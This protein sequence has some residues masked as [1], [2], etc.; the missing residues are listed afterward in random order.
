MNTI[1]KFNPLFKIIPARDN[2]QN[3][4]TLAQKKEYDAPLEERGTKK[5][6]RSVEK[7]VK[8]LSREST[9]RT[10]TPELSKKP[11]ESWVTGSSSD[12]QKPSAQIPALPPGI[13]VGRSTEAPAQSSPQHQVHERLAN[14]G[15]IS[16]TPSRSNGDESSRSSQLPNLPPGMTISR[17][18][19]PAKTPP[20]E[21][22]QPSILT[23][24]PPG[25][26]I[27]GETTSPMPKLP[28]GISIDSP[29]SRLPPGISF[30]K[31]REEEI[32]EPTSK[33]Q[34]GEDTATEDP[35]SEE[36]SQ[37]RSPRRAKGT[38]SY[39][40]PPLNKKM[41][42]G[43]NSQTLIGGKVLPGISFAK[44]AEDTPKLN[45][46]P[47]MV[48][49]KSTNKDEAV[50]N[51]KV[52]SQSEDSSDDASCAE[53]ASNGLSKKKISLKKKRSTPRVS[54]EKD[55]K[56]VDEEPTRLRS[57]SPK[58]KEPRAARGRS[59]LARAKIRATL[60]EDSWSD[61]EAA[62]VRVPY[63]ASRWKDETKLQLPTKEGEVEAAKSSQINRKAWQAL[64]GESVDDRTQVKELQAK[65]EEGPDEETH[66]ENNQVDK[67]YETVVIK[68][69]EKKRGRKPKESQEP[70]P[71]PA[72][73]APMDHQLAQDNEETKVASRTPGNRSRQSRLMEDLFDD[74]DD[75]SPKVSKGRKRRGVKGSTDSE[76]P[77]SQRVSGR[78]KSGRSEGSEPSSKSTSPVREKS[79]AVVEANNVEPE[80]V[81]VNH[82]SL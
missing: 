7:K 2:A 78:R 48:I 44:S 58:G 21:P 43:D 12:V 8:K 5:K 72:S 36:E 11:R 46:P 60:R 19:L 80:E 26:S 49:S 53:E 56:V 77:L 22:L 75:P 79:T 62:G 82:F 33:Y 63:K 52:I 24:L 38:I 76:E 31:A 30:G 73:P 65:E 34:S 41:R 20:G 40:E 4:R 1:F 39:Q 3:H 45:L 32:E 55:A 17:D 35:I 59:E 51:S 29:V 81:S 9:S 10:P 42:Q 27:G 54:P 57:P 71:A 64:G 25:I 23:K 6:G 47:G 74:D 14:L 37:T 18:S 15:G 69:K 66:S 70:S 67:D 61:E 16:L 50:E 28:P 68:P 13:V